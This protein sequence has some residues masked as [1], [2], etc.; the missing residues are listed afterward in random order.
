MSK[1]EDPSVSLQTLALVIQLVEN[2]I[3]EVEKNFET[4]DV[5]D[6]DS[7]WHYDLERCADNLK[8]V[9]LH[10]IKTRKVINFPKYDDLVK[11]NKKPL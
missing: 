9:Y 11:K 2:E 10:E 1:K 6:D 5:S 3:R 8:D 4:N 7:I